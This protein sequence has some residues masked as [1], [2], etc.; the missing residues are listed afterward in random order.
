[1][2]YDTK[3][4]H[5]NLAIVNA[6]SLELIHRKSNLVVTQKKATPIIKNRAMP[7]EED[8]SRL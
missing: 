2:V 3:N 4:L 7:K 8:D 5:P 6:L 1:M